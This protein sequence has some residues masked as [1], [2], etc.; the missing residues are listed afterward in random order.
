MD[1]LNEL[2]DFLRDTSD[3]VSRTTIPTDQ[4]ELIRSR[5]S[6][7]PEDYLTFLRIVGAGDLKSSSIK[8]YPNLCDLEDFGLEDVYSIEDN[9]VFFGDNYS[10]DFLG[11]DLSEGKD[12]VIEF[13]HD[14]ETIH[15]TGKTFREFVR[16][17]FN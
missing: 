17:F 14:S 10:G 13:W 5:S 3:E 2:N 15:R 4:L 7:I 16:E 6:S 9:I 12:E 8:I 1:F 11:F